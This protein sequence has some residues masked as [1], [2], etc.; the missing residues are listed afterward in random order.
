MYISSDTNIWIYD[1]L[2]KHGLLSAEEMDAAMDSLIQA[3]ETGICRLP[4]E[5]LKKRKR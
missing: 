3:V 2:F 1:Q 5:E 4:M